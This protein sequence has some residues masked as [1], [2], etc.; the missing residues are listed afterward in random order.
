MDRGRQNGTT[1]GRKSEKERMKLEGDE[2]ASAERFWNK[3]EARL[4]A[5]SE[6]RAKLREERRRTT[7]ADAGTVHD[8][9]NVD[10]GVTKSSKTEIHKRLQSE[11]RH[12]SEN[13]PDALLDLDSLFHSQKLL[14]GESE[15]Q[16][17]RS[18]MRQLR[19]HAW[20]LDIETLREEIGGKLREYDHCKFEMTERKLEEVRSVFYVLLTLW[21]RHCSHFD[22]RFRR[23]TWPRTTSSH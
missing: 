17:K 15:G 13:E 19:L 6:R 23:K 18:K 2:Y 12:D 11:R 21:P 1:S 9:E 4:K 8:E 20:L 3:R 22:G 16:S 14:G 5:A 10:D 7:G